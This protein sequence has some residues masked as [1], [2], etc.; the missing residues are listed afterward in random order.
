M[1]QHHGLESCYSEYL[2]SCIKDNKPGIVVASEKRT[3]EK[4]G[5]IDAR[6][7]SSQG[8]IGMKVNYE[9]GTE[10]RNSITT[11]DGNHYLIKF[12]DRKLV[13]VY[14]AKDPINLLDK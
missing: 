11:K 5:K 10:F 9:S 2:Y 13:S 1:P 3:G 8:S 6:Y 4:E 14:G 7:Q 12:C